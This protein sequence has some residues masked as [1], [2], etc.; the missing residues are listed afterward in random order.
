MASLLWG[1]CFVYFA[2]YDVR[3]KLGKMSRR[4]LVVFAEDPSKD[5]ESA[6]LS[7]YMWEVVFFPSLPFMGVMLFPSSVL[8]NAPGENGASL[9]LLSLF[10]FFFSLLFSSSPPF[11]SPSPL[12]FSP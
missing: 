11:F 10:L 4:S 1:L 2:F 6:L 8:G 7:F 5:L 9:A 12:L 3:R